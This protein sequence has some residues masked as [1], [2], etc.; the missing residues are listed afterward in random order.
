MLLAKLKGSAASLVAVWALALGASCR[1]PA[2]DEKERVPAKDANSVRGTLAAVGADKNTVT[3]TVHAFDRRTGERADTQRTFP[4]AKGA[5]FVQDEVEVKLA[6]L[7]T[8]NAAVVKLDGANAAS[9]TVD[10]GT[11]QGQFRSANVERNTITVL[12][13][14]NLAPQVFHLLKAPQVLDADGRAVK[15]EDL[16]PGTTLSITKS[17]E[18]GNTAVRVRV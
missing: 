3:I 17:V 11:T 18:D 7:K 8:G 1:A 10:G 12:A 14:R 5:K 4:L 6:E 15:L 16:K 2:A 9:V 13:G